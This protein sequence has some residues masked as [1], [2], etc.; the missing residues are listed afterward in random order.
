MKFLRLNKCSCLILVGRPCISGNFTI[1]YFIMINH[2]FNDILVILAMQ[3]QNGR[4]LKLKIFRF[5]CLRQ[6]YQTQTK[7]STIL[8][9]RKFLCLLWEVWLCYRLSINI[10]FDQSCFLVLQKW[11]TLLV[12]DVE[13]P[14]F[15]IHTSK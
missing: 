13:L 6:H 9:K 4:K 14:S 2:S 1:N 3:Q 15:K 8:N 12:Q 10:F 5:R 11:T 7:D